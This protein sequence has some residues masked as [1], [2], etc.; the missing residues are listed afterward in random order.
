MSH[1]IAHK[2]TLRFAIPFLLIVVTSTIA[3]GQSV[4]QYDRGTPPQHASGVSSFGSYTSA[5]LGNVNLSNGTL[6]MAIPLGTVGGRGFSIPLTLN[7]SSK[8]WSVSK[9]VDYVDGS[10]MVPYASYGAGDFLHDWHYRLTPGWNV[11]IAPLL[12]ASSFGIDPLTYPGCGYNRYLTKLTL[13]LPDKG[14]IELRDDYTDGA[15]HYAGT[16]PNTGNCKWYDQ[17]RGRRWHAAD[18][19]G[20]VFIS[21]VDNAIVNGDFTGV[22]I[23]ADGT[24]YR[25][26]N[27]VVPGPYIG[28]GRATSITDGNGNQITITYPTSD[29]VDYTDQLN[30]VTKIKKNTTDPQTGQGVALLVELPGYGGPRYYKVKLGQMAQNYRAGINPGGSV[31]TGLNNPQGYYMNFE[32]LGSV[33][34]VL[35]PESYCLFVERLDYQSVV[36]ELVLPDNRSL[37]F[38]YNEYGEVAEVQLPTAGKMQY[39]YES[40]DALP[41]G[42]SLPAEVRTNVIPVTI[43]GIDRALVARRTYPDGANLEG[44]WTYTYTASTTDVRAF[45]ATG[46]L[47]RNE[48]HYFMP[49]THYIADW[50]DGLNGTGYSL[51]STGL[52]SRMELRNAADVV[53]SATENDWTQRASVSWWTGYTQQQPS[54]DNRINQTRRYF[55]NGMMAKVQTLYDQYN[56]PTEVKEYDYD[57]TLKR[58]TVTSY[59]NANNGYNYQTDDSIHMLGLPVTETIYDGSGNQ[60]AQTVT[61][62]DSYT[63]DGNRDVLMNYA[64]VSQHDSSYGATKTTRGNP[65]RTG[66]W[67]N[68]TG[69]FIY[70]Y[71]RY[72]ILGNVVSFKDEAGDVGTVSFADNFGDGSNPGTPSQNPSTPTYAFATL[73]TSPPPLPGA[74][75]HTARSQYDYSSG[76]LTG[77]RDRNNIVTQTL[78]NDPFNRPTQVKSALGITGVESHVSTYYAPATVFGI[79]LAKNDTLTAS[80]LNTVDDGS[81]RSWTITDGFG[82]AIEAWKRYPEADVKVITTY[83][84]LGRVKQ[85]SNPFRPASESA[86]YTTTAYDL[87]GRVTSVTTPDNAVVSTS[88]SANTVTVTDQAGKVRKSVTDALG[89]LVEVYEDPNGLNY[90]TSYLY[91]CLDNLV[92]TTQSS[93]QRFFMY[94]SLKRLIRARNPEQSTNATLNLSDPVTG[95]SAWS[96]GYQYDAS[97]NLTQKT[98]ARGVVSTYTY[99]AFNRATT[100]DYSDTSSVSPDVK[101]FYDGATNGKGRFWYFYKGG[102]FSAGSNVDHKAVDSYDALG[103]PLVQ[104]QLFKVNGVWTPPSYQTTRT[105]NLVGSVTSQTF[106]SGHTVSYSYDSAGR[107][108]GFTGNLGDGVSRTYASSL[109]YNARNQITQELFGTQTSLYHKNHYNKRGQ[110]FDVRLSTV[111]WATDQWNWN[112]GALV[113]YYSSNYAWEGDPSTPAGPDNNGNVL[114]QQ[115]WVPADDAISTFNYTQDFY[116]YDSLNRI[117][118]AVEVHGTPSGQSG[119]DYSQVF[120]YDRWGNRTINPASSGIGINTRQFTVDTA[121]NRLGVPAGQPG[122][123]SYDNAGN[124]TND[125][126]TGVGSRT[127][128]AENKLITATDNT[129]QTTRYTY[130]ADGNR[131]R[132]Q[133]ASSQEEWQIYGMDGELLAEYRASSPASAPEKEYGYRDGQLLITA[134]GRFNVALAANGAVATASTAHTCCGFSTTGAING[135][136]RGPWGNG[137]G[138]NDATPDSV[139]DWIQVAFAGS[140]TIDEIDV[141]SLHDNYTQENTPTETQTFTLYGLLA[142]DVQYWN[143]SS[144]TTIPGG[145]VTGNNKV[146]RKFTFSPITTNKIRVYINQVPDSWSRVVEIQAFGSSADGEKLQWLVPDHL[147]TPRIVVDQTGGLAGVR[148]HDYLPFG[149]ELF[150]GAG[151]RSVTQGYAGDGV[152]QQFTIKE[153]DIE[154]GLDYFLARYYSSVQGRFTSPDEFTGGPD[155]L[156]SFANDASTNPTFYA[157]LNNPQSLNKYHYSFNNPLRYVD[158]DGHDPDPPQDPRPVVPIPAPVPGAPP[159]PLT[160]PTTSSSKV[161]NDATIIE[162]AKSVL[163]TI[164]DYTGITKLADWIRGTPA[165]APAPTTTTP[166]TQNQQPL[167]PPAPVQSKGEVKT[168]TRSPGGVTPG[169][170]VSDKQAANRLK[171]GGDTV[172][173]SRAKARQV[174]KKASG[175]GSVVHHKPHQ[176]GFRPHYHDKKHKNG[177]SFYD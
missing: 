135:N 161:P 62:Y 123:M 139:P 118:S 176:P 117:Q 160:L 61:E 29:E 51:W 71:P 100:V 157:D 17:Y 80:D 39:D 78:Y 96:V 57:Q 121:T 60:R 154:T 72:D 64:S 85:T 127:Y 87:A 136:Y 23:T 159:L 12:H 45:S 114:L 67:L 140:K 163:D 11:G 124:L 90:Q 134:T 40:K 177:H 2:L 25:F 30:R 120:A 109:T 49:A 156:F 97:G 74:S 131:V 21:D 105:Y 27:A 104:R 81:I 146:W 86:L 130:D 108:A 63:N 143:G 142:F 122:A 93:Q 76:L 65:T 106:P 151:G 137:E 1:R 149:E 173:S 5:D 133:I 167:P 129:N 98:D 59:L 10:A 152:R 169:K 46:T 150:A 138:W 42:V 175:G 8:V 70:T 20:L 26:E 73:Y 53:M 91:D 168:A 170:T 58:R 88:Y 6:N 47:L 128:D 94:D 34:Y 43:Y 32:G 75:V 153:R 3:R 158:P 14:E 66:Q 4:S 145:S 99:D 69:S 18:G 166:P 35:F 164:C 165:P 83:D 16:N 174:A 162:G 36:T 119:Q 171:S 19:S 54:N 95:N 52:E 31:V 84:G 132:R 89:R 112:R 102:D 82:R 141:F 110:L 77:F 155:E 48:R 111:P 33:G 79:T 107:T 7:Y 148:R 24:R 147:G 22:L 144:W 9:D 50:N 172:S 44:S 68:T 113:N 37:F 101:W 125:T 56:N 28:I 41:T 126:Y 92:R 55:E 13:S 116:A 115:H 38:K 15:P 103:R